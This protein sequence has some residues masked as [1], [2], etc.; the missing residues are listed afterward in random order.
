MKEIVNFEDYLSEIYHG[1]KKGTLITVKK[2]DMI[3]P[4]AISWGTIGI[5][6]NK[7]I[8]IVFIRQ[9]RYTRE[10]LDSINEFTINIPL[11]TY[12]KDIIK[13]KREWLH[14][15]HNSFNN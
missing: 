1:V 2:D 4:M 3:N 9:S 15:L 8:F 5:Q 13:I 6:W 11:N 10:I 12:D 7:P 14:V